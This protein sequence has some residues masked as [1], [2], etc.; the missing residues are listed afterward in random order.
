MKKTT[1]NRSSPQRQR[2]KSFVES[3]VS[4]SKYAPAV[5]TDP[6]SHISCGTTR[7]YTVLLLKSP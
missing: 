1:R 6:L 4:M 7:F 3:L 5:C 2:R